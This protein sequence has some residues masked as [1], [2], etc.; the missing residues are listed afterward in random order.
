MRP[1]T[2]LGSVVALLLGRRLIRSRTRD[3]E[4]PPG[5]NALG[6]LIKD[7]VTRAESDYAS[8]KTRAQSVLTV[9]GILVTALAGL[10]ALAIGRDEHLD[11]SRFTAA[12]SALTLVSFFSATCIVLIIF[13][14]SEAHFPNAD[15][16]ETYASEAWE[17]EGWDQQVAIV[18]VAYLKSLRK[19]NG[20]LAKKLA[21]A[22]SFQVLG[23]LGA[24]VMVLSLLDTVL[25]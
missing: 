4:T 25:R 11:L 2:I 3:G 18:L 17:A 21:L 9:S 7:E 19:A 20:S 16:L 14:P 15:H 1:G 12:A 22:I 6:G 24:T 13:I 5:D 8:F 10:L 23:L